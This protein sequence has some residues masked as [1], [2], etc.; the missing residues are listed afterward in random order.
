MQ[1]EFEATGYCGA[2]PDLPRFQFRH[3]EATSSVIRASLAR[4]KTRKLWLSTFIS[5]VITYRRK[6]SASRLYAVQSNVDLMERQRY[7]VCGRVRGL[8]V[9]DKASMLRIFL[10]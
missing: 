3:N 7:V 8:M 5:H 2:L 1:L 9:D 6:I 10:G 4:P